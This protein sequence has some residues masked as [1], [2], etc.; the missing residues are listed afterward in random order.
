MNKTL[1]IVDAQY[2][3]MEGGKLP[4]EGATKA[5]DNIVSLIESGEYSTIITTQDWHNGKHCSF[6]EQGGAFPEHCVQGTH[7][8]DIYAP[9]AKAIQKIKYFQFNLKK[10][11]TLEEF[12]AFED[13]TSGYP[14]WKEYNTTDSECPYIQFH[15]DEVVH[16]CGLAGDICVMQTAITLKDLNPVIADNLT[17]SLDDGNFRTLADQNDITIIEV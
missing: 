8:A 13:K 12:S 1:I 10:G 2:D 9:I 17:A 3:F 11:M 7:G 15:E 14:H 5:L 16:I 6:K 4:V